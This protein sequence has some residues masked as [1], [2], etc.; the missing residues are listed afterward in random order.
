MFDFFDAGKAFEVSRKYNDI[1]EWANS[2]VENLNPSVKGYSNRQINL[3]LALIV[4]EQALR[5]VNYID[6]FNRFTEIYRKEGRVL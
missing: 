1:R 3:L 5:D 2:V 4:N 6:V